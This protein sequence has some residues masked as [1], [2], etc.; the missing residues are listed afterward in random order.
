MKG[1]TKTT[2]FNPI[3]PSVSELRESLGGGAHC[4]HNQKSKKMESLETDK[5]LK[6]I[7]IKNMNIFPLIQTI[8]ETPGSF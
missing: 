4:A 3:T 7:Q 8:S 1:G 5:G 2:L 6:P